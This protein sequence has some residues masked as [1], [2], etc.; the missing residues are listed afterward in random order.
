MDQ[1]KLERRRGYNREYYHRN[2]N[3]INESRKKKYTYLERARYQL[4]YWTKKVREL[5]ELELRGYSEE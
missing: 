4:E 1:S 3:K 2:K 5:E